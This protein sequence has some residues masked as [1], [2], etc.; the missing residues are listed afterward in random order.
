[1][2]QLSA[3]LLDKAVEKTTTFKKDNMTLLAIDVVSQMSDFLK[4]EESNQDT[5]A[6]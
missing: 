3:F 2:Q 5:K 4:A 1:M 6:T